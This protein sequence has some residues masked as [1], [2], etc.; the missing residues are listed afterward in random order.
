MATANSAPN[1]L[2]SQ[3]VPFNPTS[4]DVFVVENFNGVP[5]PNDSIPAYGTAHNDM[6]KL[7]SWPDHK[8]CLQTQPD[9]KGNYQRWYVADQATQ[10]VY[11]WEISDSGP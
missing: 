6:S 1:L 4:T 5:P 2:P 9:E 11:N 3:R 7:K 10:N 8:F